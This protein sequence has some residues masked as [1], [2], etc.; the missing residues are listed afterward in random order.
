MAH[1]MRGAAAITGLGITPMG[2]IFGKSATELAADAVALAIADSGLAKDS[3][4]GLL[5][6]AGIISSKIAMGKSSPVLILIAVVIL[7]VVKPL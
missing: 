7:A 5:V 1:R 4:D 2:R 6:N 3:I